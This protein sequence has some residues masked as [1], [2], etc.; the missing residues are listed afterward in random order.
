VRVVVVVLVVWLIIKSTLSSMMLCPQVFDI[1]LIGGDGA[2]ELLEALDIDHKVS[3]IHQHSKVLALVEVVVV[4]V[5]V[6]PC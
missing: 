5:V 4:V 2:L 6:A 3:E 1:I